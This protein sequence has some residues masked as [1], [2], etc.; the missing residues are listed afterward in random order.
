MKLSAN[1]QARAYRSVHILLLLLIVSGILTAG[2]WPF[3]QPR[4][5]VAWLGNRNGLRFQHPG[6][7]LSSGYLN[8]G[9][10]G[11]ADSC[12]LELWLQPDEDDGFATILAFS[13]R[14]NAELFSVRQNHTGLTLQIRGRQHPDAV[15]NVYFAPV[16]E[17]AIPTFLTITSGPEGTSAYR[18]G[19]LLQTYPQF[20]VSID[21][22]TG[23]IIL[24]TSAVEN[25]SWSGELR[26]LAIYSRDL[27]PSEVIEHFKSWT[28]KGRPSSANADNL[29][30]YLFDERSGTEI[31]GQGM[32]GLD[33]FIPRRYSIAHQR[34]LQWPWTEFRLA[35]SYGNKEVSWSY[36][37]NILTNIGGFIPLGIYACG[38]FRRKAEPRTPDNGTSR[39]A[40]AATIAFGALVSLA[41][42]VLQAY[43]PT[44]ESGLTDVITNTLGTALGVALYAWRNGPIRKNAKWLGI[45]I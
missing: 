42:E 6:T 11:S 44:R 4:N 21:P 36:W 33:L 19:A 7:V 14:S 12:S 1:W 10:P 32:A 5:N 25:A 27:T 17:R 34:F 18:D 38:F 13:S 45:R 35:V 23:Q 29:A 3:H 22:L 26:G 41:I 31:R 2:L 28:Q 15:P 20:R 9:D 24:G 8:L 43:L 37:K 39:S 30:L 16:F 40:I